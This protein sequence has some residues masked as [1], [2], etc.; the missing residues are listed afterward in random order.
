MVKGYEADEPVSGGKGQQLVP[1]P[2][3]IRERAP[4]DTTTTLE[5]DP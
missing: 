1:W 3:R 2:N 4:D 5:F